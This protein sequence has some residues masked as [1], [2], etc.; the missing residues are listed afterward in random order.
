MIVERSFI[1]RLTISKA[2][3][4]AVGSIYEAQGHF[5]SREI[6]KVQ[7]ELLVRLSLPALEDFLNNY[8]LK[9]CVLREATNSLAN[10]LIGRLPTTCRQSVFLSALLA[11]STQVCL[12]VEIMRY[13]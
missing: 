10:R 12:I 8:F 4:N 13:K 6:I 11:T 3:V 9:V 1:A 7:E 2:M 5:A